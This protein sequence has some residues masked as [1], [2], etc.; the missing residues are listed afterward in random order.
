[1]R[2]LDGEIRKTIEEGQCQAWKA[3]PLPDNLQDY[4]QGNGV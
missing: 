2:G 4:A 3:E 1:M